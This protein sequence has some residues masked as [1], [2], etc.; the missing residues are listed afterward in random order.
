M[1]CEESHQHFMRVGGL[2]KSV[3]ASPAPGFHT[4]NLE[5]VK[6]GAHTGRGRGTHCFYTCSTFE[7]ERHQR[8]NYILW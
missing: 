6:E 8:P 4:L 3:L 5:E 2:H 1:F 7:D